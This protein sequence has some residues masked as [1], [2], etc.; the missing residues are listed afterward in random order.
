M[1]DGLV[2]GVWAC[3][4]IILG[5]IVDAMLTSASS[6]LPSVELR[7]WRLLEEEYLALVC[8]LE[9]SIVRIDDLAVDLFVVWHCTNSKKRRN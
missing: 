7:T 8:E 9:E 6:L 4:T 2:G 3:K 5:D 1:G